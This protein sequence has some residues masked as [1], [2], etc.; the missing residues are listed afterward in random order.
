MR[1]LMEQRGNVMI[2]IVTT[3]GYAPHAPYTLT[4]RTW[5][6]YRQLRHLRLLV[7]CVIGMSLAT[8]AISYA[9]RARPILIGALS[10]S[11]GP[12]SG[13]VGLRDGLVQLGYHENKDFVLGVRFIQGDNTALPGAARE[14]TQAGADLLFADSNSTAKALQQVSTQ[15]PIV[16]VAVEDPVGSGLVKSYAEP[17]GNITGVAT[18]DTELG[19]KRLQLFHELLPALKRVLFLYDATDIDSEQAATL[20][21]S[22]AKRLGIEFITKVVNTQEEAQTFLSQA[23]E[24]KIDGILA[25]RCCDL[26]IPELILDASKK[27]HIPTMYTT[28]AFWI[29]AG[30]LASFG[31]D[32]Y[33]SGVQAARLVDKIL[34]GKR[35]ATVPVE[36]NSTIELTINLKRAKALGLVISPRMLVRADYVIQ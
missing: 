29:E 11:W 36:V 16:F 9:K 35:P 10:E 22:A 8:S 33:T 32:F 21:H 3:N 2:K 28:K 5:T 30:A 4:F 15:I 24:R 20:Y 27:Q 7:L 6:Q 14:L 1:I 18:L 34:K 31:S 23:K 26:N 17:R 19:P 13:I 25:P 12:T